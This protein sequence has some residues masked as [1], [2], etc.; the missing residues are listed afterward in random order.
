MARDGHLP[1]T[2]AAVQPRFQ[3]PHHAEVAVGLLVAAVALVADVRAAIGFSSFAVLAYYAVTNASALT[4]R[5]S[6]RS[7]VVPTIGLLGCVALAF[8]LPTA[9]TVTGT[10]VLLVGALVYSLK[11]LAGGHRPNRTS[12]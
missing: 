7:V 3:V 11:R 4:V 12:P 8:S 5:P 1:R 10:C 9:S 6:T 2:L